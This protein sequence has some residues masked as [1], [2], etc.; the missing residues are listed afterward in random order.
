MIGEVLHRKGKSELM[1]QITDD[2]VAVVFR[3]IEIIPHV[4]PVI[5]DS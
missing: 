2:R 5:G 4:V 3:R 1:N